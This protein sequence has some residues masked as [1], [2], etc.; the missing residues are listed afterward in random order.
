M[1]SRRLFSVKS[2]K[3]L[4]LQMYNRSR[5]KGSRFRVQGSGLRVQGSGFKRSRFRVQGSRV[6]GS[7]FRVWVF[8]FGFDPTRRDQACPGATGC[9]YE[10]VIT[11]YEPGFTSPLFDM[12][13]LGRGFSSAAGLK[14]GQSYR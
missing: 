12:P 9:G 7:E 13:G 2:F 10:I 3:T 4:D 1:L 14:N 6:Q 11:F 8:A 5:F